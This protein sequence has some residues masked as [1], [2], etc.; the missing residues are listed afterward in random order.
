M[1]A[2]DAERIAAAIRAGEV[3]AV[4]QLDVLAGFMAAEGVPL[5][6]HRGSIA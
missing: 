6:L 3:D 5:R 2:L 4:W 1:L